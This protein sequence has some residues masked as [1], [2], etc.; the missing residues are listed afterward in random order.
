[1]IDYDFSNEK[2]ALLAL[3][4]KLNQTLLELAALRVKIQ[5]AY[6][7]LVEAGQDVNS[8]HSALL[9]ERAAALLVSCGAVF[10]GWD[11]FK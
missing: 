3:S 9:R 6:E 10:P 7:C 1:M 4:E 5:E 8:E 11:K 2:H